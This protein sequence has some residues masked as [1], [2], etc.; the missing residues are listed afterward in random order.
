M[1][2]NITVQIGS[3]YGDLRKSEKQAADYILN[4]MEEAAELPLDRLAEAAKV[5]QPTVLRMLKAVGYEGFP[6]SAG[7]GAG[8]DRRRR[9]RTGIGPDVRVYA[10]P[11][12][13]TGCGAPEY[14][15]DNGADAGGNTEESAAQN[16]PESHRCAEV[17]PYIDST[18]QGPIITTFFYPEKCHFTFSQMYEYIKDRG[19]AIYPGKVTE[20]ETFRIGNIGEIYKEDIEKVCAIM[21]EFLEEYNHEEN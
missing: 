10:G 2:N 12:E 11:E 5:S 21:K 16:I 1:K 15:N 14:Y 7:G 4:H 18:H 17:R 9:A 20:A 19:Y 13:R 3:G 6:L 8:K